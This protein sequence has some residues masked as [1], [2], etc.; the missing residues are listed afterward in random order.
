MNEKKF[1]CPAVPLITVDPYFSVWSPDETLN[2][3]DTVH[4][5]GTPM[6][7]TGS[8]F[9]D[10]EEHVF[11]GYE[12]NLKKI[13]QRSL[14][15]SALLT[16]AVYANE[17]IELT[18]RFMT[19]LF[20]G[21]V[22]L[23]SRPVS[24]L[25]LTF[26][27]LDGKAHEVRAKILVREEICLNEVRQ[28]PVVFENVDI[29]GIPTVKMGN[30]E[31]KVLW[32]SGDNVRIDWGYFYL[33]MLDKNAEVRPCHARR[34]YAYAES[35]LNEG[36]DRLVLFSYDDVK[37]INYFGKELSSAWNADGMTIK[38]AIAD[39]ARDGRY[40]FESAERFSS[41][42]RARAESAGGEKY[43][44]IVTL[45]YR[46]VVAAHKI[47]VDENGEIIFISKE[48][49]S[50][51]C[52]ATVDVS[53]PSTPL[54]LI[55][56]PEL[57]K[58]MMRPIYKFAKSEAWPY[59]F[60]PHDAGQFPLVTGQVYG[61]ERDTGKFLFE[62]QM[63][64]EES[65]NMIIMEACVALA[66]GKAD[67]AAEHIDV[68]EKW[69]QYL[70]KYGEDPEEQLCTD[71]FAG[72][73]A[74]NCNLSLKAIMGVRGMAIILSMLG[75][76]ADA[77]KYELTAKNMAKSWLSRAKNADGTYRLAFD[78]EGTFSM[79]YNMVWDKIWGT[80]LFPKLSVLFETKGYF[81]REKKYGLP[82]DSRADY[83][84]TDWL[85]W[86]ATLA[87]TKRDFER[88]IS[89]MWRA[90]TESPSRVPLTDWYDTESSY[91]V[92]FQNRTVQGGL[93]IKMLDA[94]G[95][96]RAGTLK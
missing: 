75:R 77:E 83:T 50:N 6:P 30:S 3:V 74:H 93:F 78:K 76:C 19:P 31:Q 29:A 47:A 61:L 68:L 46:Q 94:E 62:K 26:R 4:W 54:F 38:E 1:R 65:G 87:G 69:C 16:T 20:P 91:K 82:L 53:Y 14:D 57:V 23:M 33:S 2:Y 89:P 79:K 86:T 55:Y 45:A 63:P 48:C 24:Y 95:K 67:F 12:P 90:F 35:I 43:A 11:L 22:K 40:L 59:D 13:K 96:L 17:K 72:H 21:D 9:I 88:L 32:R 7:I 15:V 10:G 58:G 84:K 39:A 51:G 66:E 44:D 80:G 52:A 25:A 70:I 81:K 71:D 37:S 41:D 73:L 5:T 18:A 64:V 36:E 56:D 92:G 27:S 8:V 85:V 42:L 34:D 49:F 60:A 28:S